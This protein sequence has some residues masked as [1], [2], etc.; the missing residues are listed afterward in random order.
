[1]TVNSVSK[2]LNQKKAYR[3]R[4]RKHNEYKNLLKEYELNIK[5]DFNYIKENLPEFEKGKLSS[6]TCIEKQ[7]FK[8]VKNRYYRNRDYCRFLKRKIEKT[9]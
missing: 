3:K 7:H 2:H 1:M 6:M 4:L 8:K 9:A 5:N